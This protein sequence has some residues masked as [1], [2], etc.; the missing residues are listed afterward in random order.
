MNSKGVSQFV[1]IIEMQRIHQPEYNHN[2]IAE[3]GKGDDINTFNDDRDF[4]R[5][6]PLDVVSSC[7]SRLEHDWTKEPWIIIIFL[8]E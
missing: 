3:S 8:K 2:G 6:K 7:H 1:W 5:D 4:F